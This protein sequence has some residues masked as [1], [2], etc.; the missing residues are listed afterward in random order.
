MANFKEFQFDGCMS[1]PEEMDE[2]AFI[3]KFLEIIEELGW[4]YGGGIN[5]Y[6]EEKE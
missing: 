5:R 4:L 1:V 6:R 2:D 3:E